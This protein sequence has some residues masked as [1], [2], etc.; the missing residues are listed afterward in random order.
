MYVVHHNPASS[1]AKSIKTYMW[2]TVALA[3]QCSHH[4]GTALVAAAAA[5][6]DDDDDDDDDVSSPP[7]LSVFRQRL[8]TFL[9]R[10]S[11]SD[12]LIHQIFDRKTHTIIEFVPSNIYNNEHHFSS[13]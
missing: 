11:Y 13:F 4:G 10:H 7:S 5:A 6:D 9:F 12:L 8:K 2:K 3:G 1:A